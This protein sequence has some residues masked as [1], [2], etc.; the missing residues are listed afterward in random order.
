MKAGRPAA[1]WGLG[2]FAEGVGDAAETHAPA[3]ASHALLSTR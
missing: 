1:H 3:A 2:A